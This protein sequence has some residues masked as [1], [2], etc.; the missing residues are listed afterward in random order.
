VV[1]CIP[2]DVHRRFGGTYCL[3]LQAGSRALL[4][5]CVRL[6]VCLLG[7]FDPED[8]RRTFLRNVDGLWDYMASRASSQYSSHCVFIIETILCLEK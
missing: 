8:G 5:S 1:P 3:H 2:L 6:A 7:L 4:V